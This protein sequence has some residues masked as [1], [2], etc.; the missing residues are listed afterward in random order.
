M[1]HPSNKGIY[2]DLCS[3]EVLI[4]SNEITYYTIN[5]KKVITRKNMPKD[6]NDVLDLDFCET[7]YQKFYDRVYKISLIN[8]EKSKKYGK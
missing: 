3:K 1:I 5:M 8:D 4:Q 2:C 6:V 7:C